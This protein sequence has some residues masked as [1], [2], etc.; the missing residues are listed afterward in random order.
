MNL[1]D[2]VYMMPEKTPDPKHVIQSNQELLEAEHP[3][4]ELLIWYHRLGHLPLS[5]IKI[6]SLLDII[7]KRIANTNPPKCEE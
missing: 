7:T 4:A 5:K 6:L 2:L 3:Q 1:T